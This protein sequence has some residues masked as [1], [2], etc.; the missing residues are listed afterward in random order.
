[1]KA[2]QASLA[3]AIL[4]AFPLAHADDQQGQPA[5]PS[6]SQDERLREELKELEKAPSMPMTKE[7]ASGATLSQAQEGYTDAIKN[8]A[9]VVATNSAGTTNDAFAIRGIKLNLFANYRLDGGLPVTGVITNPV[10]NKV[11]VETLKGANALMFGIASPAGIINFIP[12]RAGNRD[13]TSVGFAGNAFGQYSTNVDLGRR[14]GENREFG[15]RF[16]ASAMH[17]ENGIRNMGGRGEF[18]SLGLD[19]RVTSR[20]T[21]QG[22]FE[23]YSRHIPEQAGISLKPA[24]NG[25]VPLPRVLDPRR[26]LSGRWDWYNPET[27][28]YQGRLDYLLSD[29]WK[30]L[31]QS[32][33]SSSSRHRT[34]VRIGGYDLVTGANGVVTVQPVT[35]EYGNHFTRAELR[36]H[37]D[38][39]S[40][41]HDLTVGMSRTS[42]YSLAKDVQ[43][44]TLPQRQ[45]IFDP[46]ELAAPVY[47]KPGTAN[48]AQISTDEGLYFYDTLSVARPLK[49]LMG[50]RAV[51]DTEKVGLTE[52]SSRVHSPAYGA[53]YDVLPHVTLFASVMQGL[54]AGG[55]APA[56]A[57]NANVTLAPAT[58]KQK[59]LGVRVSDIW[60]LTLSASY[61]D[62]VRGNAVTDPVTNIFA[63]SGDLTYKGFES[64]ASFDA[65]RDLRF[66]GAVQRLHARQDSP[67]QPLI[68]G[69]VP[70]NT[71]D[72][73]G[74]V[75]VS[76]AMPQL[77]GLTLRAV[78]KL[79]SKRPLNAQDQGYLPG[80]ALYDLGASYATRIGGKPA[81][82]NVSVDNVA[83]RRYWNSIGT[84]TLGIGMDR[85]IKFSGK[86]DF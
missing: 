1:M 65:T 23:Y 77:K 22:D 5:S 24:V 43:N 25:V 58:S 10:E 45:N 84:G 18:A 78:A 31:V 44:L 86:F 30:L 21:V 69:K 16:N 27:Y 76:Y 39:W 32:G 67:K 72:W 56:N 79:I 11:R 4:A 81:S 37:F 29:N 35:N 42:R 49:L 26:L 15:L 71:P 2:T 7:V 46:I 13:V 63:Y 38:T 19:F 51:H 14:F 12:K 20:L 41:E 6:P 52:S 70:E 53:L 75:G 57:A 33:Y 9:G 54:E 50:L 34:T 55:T 80:Y 59:E 48:P 8:V 47:T 85:S 17:I 64:T 83:N 40:V 28:N 61:F 3:L 74:N 73:S 36:G 60:G 82:F 66:T 68:D 62:I